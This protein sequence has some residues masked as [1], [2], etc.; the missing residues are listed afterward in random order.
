MPQVLVPHVV[1]VLA[2]VWCHLE[3]LE[4]V[5]V[6]VALVPWHLVLG[7]DFIHVHEVGLA[8]HCHV[9]DCD[10]HHGYAN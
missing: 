5:V 2:I 9:M 8:T 1:V 7:D 6:E 10:G 3:L 4:V